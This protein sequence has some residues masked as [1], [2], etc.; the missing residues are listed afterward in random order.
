[1]ADDN[2][3]NLQTL[4]H[5][6]LL[7][8]PRARIANPIPPRNPLTGV[9]HRIGD[10]TA[11]RALD[12][13]AG[14][15]AALARYLDQQTK[16]VEAN[17]R[18]HAA[19]E[20]FHANRLGL[21]NPVDQ[22]QFEEDKHKRLLARKRREKEQYEADEH[23]LDVKYRVEAKEEFKEPKF[24]AGRARFAQKIAERQVGE[25]VAR[26]SIE[27]EPEETPTPQQPVSIAAVIGDLVQKLERDVDAAEAAGKPTKQMR[28]D[29]DALNAMLK[30]I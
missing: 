17:D 4:P 13:Q 1:M 30:R 25:A 10:N 22:E 24:A 20:K 23:I 6:E 18:L 14:V 27:P 8:D 2:R 19:M 5:L 9:F 26:S 11:A 3:N 29:R 28:D 7:A 12:S 16:A 21:L 15:F